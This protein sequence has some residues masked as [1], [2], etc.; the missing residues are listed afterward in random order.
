ME[1]QTTFDSVSQSLLGFFDRV[2]QGLKT[3]WDGRIAENEQQARLA[4]SEAQK[5]SARTIAELERGAA[6]S[7]WSDPDAVTAGIDLSNPQT[8]LIGAA[9]VLVAVAALRGK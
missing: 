8:L 2:N 1:G 7:N 5:N 4:Y 9:V 3:Y 6:G